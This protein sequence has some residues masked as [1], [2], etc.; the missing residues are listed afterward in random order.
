MHGL[1]TIA[2]REESRCNSNSGASVHLP[3]NG[4]WGCGVLCKLH[5][6][7]KIHAH[8]KLVCLSVV[9]SYL[10]IS[11]I[12]SCFPDMPGLEGQQMVRLCIH[13]YPFWC[14]EV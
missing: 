2:H 4:V 1:H 10:L 6:N 5:K 7:F 8:M 13:W 11:V 3:R 9:L 14:V 12:L